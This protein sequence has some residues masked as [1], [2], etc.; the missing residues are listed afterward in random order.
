MHAS[1]GAVIETPAAP[2]VEPNGCGLCGITPPHGRQWT[3]EAGW[4][5]FVRPTQE[6]IKQRMQR[7]RSAAQLK[8]LLARQTEETYVS[9]LHHDYRTPHD[10]PEPGERP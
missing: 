1:S 9:P 8:R 7:R 6:Q 5:A 2:L 10:L 4:H 3:A